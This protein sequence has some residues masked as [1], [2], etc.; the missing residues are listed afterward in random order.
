MVKL[1]ALS[2]MSVLL[3]ACTGIGAFAVNSTSRLLGDY[4]A[5]KDIAFG[6]HGQ[7]LDV[8]TPEPQP[9]NADVVVFF[10]G[11]G[12]S[13]GSKD[14]YT[15]V[16]DALTSRG[17]VVVIPDYRKYPDVRF[18]DFVYDGAEAVAWAKA[19]AAEY[20]GNAANIHVMGH[21]AGAHLA[22]LLASDARYLQKHGMK[23]ADLRSFAGLAGPYHFIPEKQLYK[24]VFGPPERYPLMHVDNFISGDEPPMLLLHGGDDS[25][26][27]LTNL[28]TLENV[29]KEH[30]GNVQSKVYGGQGH[31]GM[32]TPFARPLR[33]SAP[34]LDDV[35]AFFQAQ[36]VK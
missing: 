7:K 27:A 21:S 29:V 18:P 4:T 5:H 34:L 30:G 26:V 12:W 14:T 28:Q 15:F 25:T 2:L 31:I 32:V 24:D 13:D 16:G 23:P 9:E 36:R 20:G 33:Q 22:A 8:Y 19:H 35:D 6:S 1:I 17:Y 10:Y 11:G 3:S